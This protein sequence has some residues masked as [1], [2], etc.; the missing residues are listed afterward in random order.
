MTLDVD[1]PNDYFMNTT[2]LINTRHYRGG[3][4]TIYSLDANNNITTLASYDILDFEV[5]IN[6][7][8]VAAGNYTDVMQVDV[9]LET[10]TDSTGMLPVDPTIPSVYL[11]SSDLVQHVDGYSLA[12][13]W[14]IYGSSSHMFMPLNSAQVCP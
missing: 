11:T 10:I 5:E 1:D 6:Y 12:G 3:V 14:E 7:A 4:Y 13:P 2:T 9:Y 8:Q